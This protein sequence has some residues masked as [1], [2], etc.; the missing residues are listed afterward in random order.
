MKR[1][2]KLIPRRFCYLFI[3]HLV[4]K[5]VNV[6]KTQYMHAWWGIFRNFS[7]F[8]PACC[9]FE[10]I[11][12][13]EIIPF[14]E[15]EGLAFAELRLAGWYNHIWFC[16]NNP[17]LLFLLFYT[18]ASIT[19]LVSAE[20]GETFTFHVISYFYLLCS[21]HKYERWYNK[22]RKSVLNLEFFDINVSNICDKI[23]S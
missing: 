13:Y 16:W 12:Q 8:P 6:M 18:C 21:I 15:R 9:L 10:G 17:L 3:L 5:A 4:K 1:K 20:S 22:L 19:V 14:V 11:F 7:L 2:I 23:T